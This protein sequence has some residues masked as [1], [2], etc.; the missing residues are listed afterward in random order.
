MSTNLSISL[1]PTAL[2]PAQA[3]ASDMQLVKSD[4]TETSKDPFFPVSELPGGKW[5]KKETASPAKKT[6]SVE[7]SIQALSRD[8]NVVPS[9]DLIKDY[10]AYADRWENPA[11][12]HE[13]TIVVGIAALVNGKV[14]IKNL[15]TRLPLDFWVVLLSLSGTGRNTLLNEFRDLLAAAGLSELIH[16]EAWGSAAY[17]EEYFSENPRGLFVWP[18]MS[19]VLNQFKQRHFAGAQEW[20]TNLYDEKVPPSSKHYRTA[21]K[22]EDQTPAIEFDKAPRTCFLATSSPAWFFKAVTKESVTGGFIPRWVPVISEEPDRSISSPR[23]PNAELLPPLVEK[24]KIISELSGEMD[25][26]S[27]RHIYD[28]WYKKAHKRFQSSANSSFAM[29]FW[30]RHRQHLL[31]LAAIYELATSGSLTVSPE[32]MKR[33]IETAERLAQNIFQLIRSSFTDEGVESQNLEDY[34]RDGKCEGRSKSEVHGF[35]RGSEYP[36]AKSRLL[37]LLEAEIVFAFSRKTA[38]RPAT[39]FVHAECVDDY[40]E[41]HTKDAPLHAKQAIQ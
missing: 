19:Q 14:W 25:F 27:V 37:M 34:I 18:E 16:Q 22:E 21:A 5:T 15:G 12:M 1:D 31:K 13:F 4:E 8:P 36:K 6:K 30:G 32:S 23:E 3:S 29:P 7:T 38:G 39:Y 9:S 10:V 20:I 24:L 11:V 33:A 40:K 41:A 2:V 28:D 35:L 17:I 26:S